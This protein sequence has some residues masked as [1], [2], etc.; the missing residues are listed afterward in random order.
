MR[1]TRAPRSFRPRALARPLATLLAPAATLLAPAA[2]LL[3]AAVSVLAL[4]PA[5]LAAASAP[6]ESLAT[7]EG[8][9][10]GRQVSVVSLHTAAHTFHV[11]LANGRKAIV[12]FPASEQQR[13]VGEVKAKGVTVKVAKVKPPPHKLRYIVGGAAIVVIILAVASLLLFRRRRRLREEE[14]GPRGLAHA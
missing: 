4:S 12:A 7:F 11:T 14:E 10:N 6:S 2:L 5:A 13:L 1:S 3:A 9:L 8:Q